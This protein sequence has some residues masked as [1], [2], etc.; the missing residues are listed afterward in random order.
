MLCCVSY[1]CAGLVPE[2]QQQLPSQA[3]QPQSLCCQHSTAIWST[4]GAHDN[5]SSNSIGDGCHV[6]ILT[7]LAAAAVKPVASAVSQIG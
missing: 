5:S 3:Q 7:M 6:V 1:A 4:L 2:K